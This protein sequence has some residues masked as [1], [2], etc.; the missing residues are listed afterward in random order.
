[1]DVVICLAS[2][3]YHIVKKNVRYIRQYLQEA[4]DFVYLI[5]NKTNKI[6]FPDSWLQKNRAVF[7]DE[8]NML[9]ELSFSHVFQTL[10]CRMV[11]TTVS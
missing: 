6:F 7:V 1:M 8:D 3:D 11:F 5:S 4:T 10:K 2:K 9:E